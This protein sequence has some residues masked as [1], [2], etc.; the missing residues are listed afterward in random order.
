MK[1]SEEK[2]KKEIIKVEEKENC[3]FFGYF[4]KDGFP[5]YIID[6]EAGVVKERRFY[7]KDTVD[8]FSN[9]ERGFWSDA[10]DKV[11]PIKNYEVD[12]SFYLYLYQRNVLEKWKEHG[13][14]IN[15]NDVN[16]RYASEES[17]LEDINNSNKSEYLWVHSWL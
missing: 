5:E 3:T 8:P 9:Y 15:F 17:L 16:M 6:W 1:W 4:I 2:T 13:G 14:K 11:T 12:L 10:R 7:G